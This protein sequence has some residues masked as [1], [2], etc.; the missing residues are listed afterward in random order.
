MKIVY[1]L[2][3]RNYGL[4]EQDA[5]IRDLFTCEELEKLETMLEVTYPDGIY[6]SDVEALFEDD[7]QYAC[8]LL[9]I[10]YENDFKMRG[11]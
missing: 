8:D 10:D 5:R 11:E 2:A 3:L 6:E 1:E 7:G 4:R 9:E